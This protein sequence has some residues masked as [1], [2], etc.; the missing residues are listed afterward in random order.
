MDYGCIGEK[1]KH[2]FSKEIHNKLFNYDYKICEI[3][4]DELDGFLRKKEFKAINVTIPYKE[5]VLPYLD[6]IDE[7]AEKIG[8]VNTIVNRQGKLCGFNTD[9]FGMCALLEKNKIQIKNKKALILGSGGTAKTARAVLKSLGAKECLTVSRSESQGC[10]SYEK[11]YALHTDA[12]VILNT[13]PCGMFPNTETVAVDLKRFTSLSAVVDAVYNPLKSRLVKEAENSGI[14]AVGGLYMLVAQAAHAAERF[15]DTSVSREKIDEVYKS[16]LKEKQNI[17]LV[18]MPAS[19]KTTIGRLVSQKLNMQFV[20]SDD[21]IVKKINMPIAAFFKEYG[22]QRF[23]EIES[24]IIFSLSKMQGCV[25]ATGGGAV[26]NEQN[27]FYLSQNGRIYFIDRDINS[28]QPTG[29]RPLSSSREDLL[30]RYNERYD[31]YKSCCDFHL[32]ASNS[33]EDNAEKIKE[34]F[35]NENTC[36]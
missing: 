2:S 30:K 14:K 1:L 13:T 5:A 7:A 18:G 27:V 8:A 28:L 3:Q 24:E 36:D 11:M 23:R 32:K 4:K 33:A 34:D 17:V 21:E 10:I 26:L 19:G 25:I 35:F 29:D 31:I 22:E 12:N 16:I 15:I 20:D 9:F 6:S